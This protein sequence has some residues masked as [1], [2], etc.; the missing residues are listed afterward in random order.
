MLNNAFRTTCSFIRGFEEGKVVLE[1][2]FQTYFEDVIYLEVGLLPVLCRVKWSQLFVHKR[3]L[4]LKYKYT[5]KKQDKILEELNRETARKTRR[6]SFIVRKLCFRIWVST[7]EKKK[8]LETTSGVFFFFGI[9]GLSLKSIKD[10]FKVALSEMQSSCLHQRMP[11]VSGTRK[12]PL[13]FLISPTKKCKIWRGLVLVFSLWSV[14][15][16][17]SVQQHECG[18]WD[19]LMWKIFFPVNCSTRCNHCPAEWYRLAPLHTPHHFL[20]RMWKYLPTTPPLV[21]QFI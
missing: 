16:L 14:W 3:S 19:L 17:W 15:W 9:M 10:C 20:L 11:S 5:L 13:P 21:L 1:N 4:I 7:G 18:E 2:N 8:R 12:Q 6:K